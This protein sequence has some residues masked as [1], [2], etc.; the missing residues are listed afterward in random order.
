MWKN[1]WFCL[2]HY[3]HGEAY[4]ILTIISLVS[5]SQTAISFTLG[6]DWYTEQ[7]CFVPIAMTFCR[8]QGNM[9]NCY[10]FS[11]THSYHSLDNFFMGLFDLKITMCLV[12][13]KVPQQIKSP[14]HTLCSKE[15]NCILY[16]LHEFL[17]VW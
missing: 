13:I 6:R 5:L 12:L 2:D 7:Q 15:D 8:Y 11:Y 16:I 1:S 3:M 9:S 17:L 14:S 4:T 10:T